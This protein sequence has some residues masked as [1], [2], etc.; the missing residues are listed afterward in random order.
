MITLR[1]LTW[2]RLMFAANVVGAGIPGLLV[3]FFPGFARQYLFDG[4]AQDG[5]VF[6]VTGSVW[7]AVGLI[8]ILGLRNPVPFTG[9]FLVQI[10]YKTV[11]ITLIGLPAMAS[12]DE[13]AAFFAWFFALVTVGFAFAVPWSLLLRKAVPG[14][15]TPIGGNAR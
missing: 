4:V 6:G 2:M 15:E 3:T 13:R 12:G 10:V 5:L 8:S 11:W 1:K 7:L 14:S 9:V